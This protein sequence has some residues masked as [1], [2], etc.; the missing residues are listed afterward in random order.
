MPAGRLRSKKSTYSVPHGVFVLIN[1]KVLLG[2]SGVRCSCGYT[3]NKDAQ[4][5]LLLSHVFCK[6]KVKIMTFV[7][8]KF[9]KMLVIPK[10]QA[11]YS[12]KAG[13]QLPGCPV[14]GSPVTLIGQQRF[15]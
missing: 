4:S 3:W 15:A 11:G 5:Y 9:S 13:C 14:P 10:W 7:P 8:G 2:T 1:T 12:V 6:C